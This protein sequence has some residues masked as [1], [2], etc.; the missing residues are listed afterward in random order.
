MDPAGENRRYVGDL[1]DAEKQVAALREREVYSPDGRY[2]LVV[3]E[4][5]GAAQI[6]IEPPPSDQGV[7]Y[8]PQRLTDCASLCY[9]PA[10]APDGSRVAFVSEDTGGDD[11]W[12]INTDGS[13]SH[14]VTLNTWEWDK[15]PTWSPDSKRIAFWSNRTGVK[16]IYVMQADGQG[17]RNISN[18]EWDEYD[19]LWI[20]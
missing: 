1:D 17:V 18:T 3:G 4:V 2:R 10:W 13:N 7:R 14:Y 5:G 12:I 20:K 15:R 11:I 16:Q 19:P 6:L 9:E 8:P